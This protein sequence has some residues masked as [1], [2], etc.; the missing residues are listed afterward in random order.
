MDLYLNKGIQSKGEIK[1][2][3]SAK[4][5]KAIKS[6]NRRRRQQLPYK[7]GGGA[8]TFYGFK[9]VDWYRLGS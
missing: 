4:Y 8:R 2:K 9:F 6:F 5:S 3:T 7:S 1:R